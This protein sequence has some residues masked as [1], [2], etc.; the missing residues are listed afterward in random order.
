MDMKN[1]KKEIL[2]FVI[3]SFCLLFWECSFPSRN[4]V[5]QNDNRDTLVCSK[6]IL[7]DLELPYDELEYFV[8][9][10]RD[11]SAYSCVITSEKGKCV[12]ADLEFSLKEKYYFNRSYCNE[13]DTT[14]CGGVR[15]ISERNFRI[16][17]YKDM[18]NEIDLCLDSASKKHDLRTLRS[19]KT[20]LSHLGDMAVMTTNNLKA[21]FSVVDGET[22]GHTDIAKALE[23]TTFRDDLNSFF[24]KYGLEVDD[25]VCQEEKYLVLKENFLK[26][27]NISK[28]LKVPDHI[29][30]VEV[31][32]GLRDIK[33]K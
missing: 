28:E 6:R 33:E 12:T 25:I 1:G 27:Q 24:R 21:H 10:G 23:M 9:I 20:I 29:M 26:S 30:D 2:L 22:Y 16:P 19:F 3:A 18:L 15:R 31:Y 13:N 4:D 32:I 17:C 8:T 5:G 14:V 7:N 11:T